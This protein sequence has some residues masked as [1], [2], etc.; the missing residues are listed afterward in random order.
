[1]KRYVCIHRSVED[2]FE[3]QHVFNPQSHDCLNCPYRTE[4]KWYDWLVWPTLIGILLML[5]I[6]L[7]KAII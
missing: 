6:C 4:F 1:M 3:C 2:G 7:L 5:G